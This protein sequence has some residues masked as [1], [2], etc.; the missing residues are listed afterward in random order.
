[1]RR[2]DLLGGDYAVLPSSWTL[3]ET[4]ECAKSCSQVGIIEIRGGAKYDA[5]HFAF[6][7][8]GEYSQKGQIAARNQNSGPA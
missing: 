8:N 4:E 3:L 6:F 5:P 7:H 2:V 1:M